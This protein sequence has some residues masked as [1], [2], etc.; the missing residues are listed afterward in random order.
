MA[1]LSQ[2]Y[3]DCAQRR[4]TRGR[5]NL[6]RTECPG[7]SD[8]PGSRANRLGM[9]GSPST[10]WPQG[11]AGESLQA[12]RYG[13]HWGASR[14][15]TSAGLSRITGLRPALPTRPPRPVLAVWH[16]RV[17]SPTSPAGTMHSHRA[18]VI[19]LPVQ[20]SLRA[21]DL[22]CK[23]LHTQAPAMRIQSPGQ[24]SLSATWGIFR[25]FPE[26]SP[27]LVSP[28]WPRADPPLLVLIYQ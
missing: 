27:R 5:T 1:P 2:A 26:A 4:R 23:S 20:A 7:S 10:M 28:P 12:Q 6:L 21:L 24:C 13:H 18:S 11:W 16:L 17:S 3:L 15:D 14:R 9:A 8:Q 25:A 19:P 22:G